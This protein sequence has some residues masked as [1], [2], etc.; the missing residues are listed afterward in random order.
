[1]RNK[2]KTTHQPSY[3]N[4]IETMIKGALS[5]KEKDIGLSPLRQMKGMRKDEK[6][7]IKGD[8]KS[9]L[10]DRK[11][12]SN[13]LNLGNKRSFY[14]LHG[15]MLLVKGVLILKLNQRKT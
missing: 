8:L 6:L 13:G 9:E 4:S 3:I 14:K 10:D 1:M 15:N 11:S 7:G 2:L 12:Q 5:D